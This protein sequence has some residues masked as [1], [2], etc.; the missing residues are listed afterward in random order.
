MA[1]VALVPD[2]GIVSVFKTDKGFGVQFDNDE[3]MR[4]DIMEF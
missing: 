2:I 3:Q 4:F 1:A